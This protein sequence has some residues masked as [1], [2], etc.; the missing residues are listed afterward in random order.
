ME[1]SKIKVAFKY[2]FGGVGAVADYLLDMLNRSL[3]FIDADS[4]AKIQ[5]VLN[6]AK[7]VLSTLEAFGWLCPTKWQTAYGKS[8]DAVEAVID[9]LSD[10]NVTAQEISAIR[11]AFEAAVKEWKSPDDDTCVDGKNL[12]LV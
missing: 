1:I 6:I 11:E 9:C 7:R 8:C 10:L 12:I 5:S 3:A 4:K 2:L